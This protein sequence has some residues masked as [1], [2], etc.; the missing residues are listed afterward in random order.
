VLDQASRT[1]MH[2]GVTKESSTAFFRAQ[3]EA[4]KDIQRFWFAR[5]QDPA[6]D[7]PEPAR[8][9]AT[10]LRPELS[11]LGDQIIHAIAATGR[12]DDSSRLRQQFDNVV[13]AE[14]LSAKH[15]DRL[16]AALVNVD[17][18][19]DRLDQI[20]AAGEIRIG[21]TGDYAPFSFRRDNELQG[22]DID[23][24]RDLAASL[25]VKPVFVQTS[26][27]T[28]MQDLADNR[29]DVGMSGISRILARQKSAFLSLP[30]H[31]GGKTPIS[32][33]EDVSKFDTLDKIDSSEVRV[34]VNPGGTNQQFVD[35]HLTHAEVR[36]FEDNRTVFDEI[37]EGRADV[38]IT[39]A[40]EVKLKAKEYPA[41]CATL[42]DK[43]FTY[44]EKAYLMPR[45]IALKEYVNTWISLRIEDGTMTEAFDKHLSPGPPR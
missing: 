13:S 38:M 17:F 16:Y 39:D 23:L 40:I 27:P 9:L 29:F 44:Q 24:A 30:Y 5:W 3:I 33:C 15:R 22:I 45:D 34:I 32:R 4:A 11:K 18:Y 28:L 36:V 12:I 10:V 21:T 35:K 8:N 1:A 14:G 43:T 19:P 41:L 2:A 6:D 26:W 7:K 20:L 42:P 25:N 37:A 31:T